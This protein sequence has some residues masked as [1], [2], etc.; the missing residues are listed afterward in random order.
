[1]TTGKFQ[2]VAWWSYQASQ[3]YN[4]P[5]LVESIR[6]TEII[7]GPVNALA[8]SK[9]A[10]LEDWKGWLQD[11]SMGFTPTRLLEILKAIDGFEAEIV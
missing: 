4:E 9:V 2:Q 11:P 8:P 3:A 5:D 6:K 10:G 1:M 7:V